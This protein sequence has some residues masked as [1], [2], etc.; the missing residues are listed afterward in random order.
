VSVLRTCPYPDFWVKY[1]PSYDLWFVNEI[2]MCTHSNNQLCSLLYFHIIK[3]TFGGFVKFHSIFWQT[4]SMYLLQFVWPMKKGNYYYRVMILSM[5]FFWFN[6]CSIWKL[7]AHS[8]RLL[9]CI[10]F[11][12]LGLAQ[13]DFKN[14]TNSPSVHH[15]FR[16]SCHQNVLYSFDVYFVS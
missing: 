14:R 3:F 1:F 13:V 5:Y 12:S 2:L 9:F 11:F 8:P 10:D 7:Q 4:T 16:I 6:D 15:V